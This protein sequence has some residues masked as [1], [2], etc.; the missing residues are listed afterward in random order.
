MFGDR[1]NLIAGHQGPQEMPV[2]PPNAI[3]FLGKL[4]G[5]LAFDVCQALCSVVL[6]IR[7]GRERKQANGQIV[8]AFVG[9]KVPMM[10]AAK[11]FD[12]RDPRT[13]VVFEFSD[14]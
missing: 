7:Q 8:R 12:Q 2:I 11:L 14:F 5:L 1:Q 9:Q 4:I 3:H 13:G 6:I 10:N